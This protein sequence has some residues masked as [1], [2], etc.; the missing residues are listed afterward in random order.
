MSLIPSY[1]PVVSP[2]SRWFAMDSPKSG[3]SK[4]HITLAIFASVAL[5]LVTFK[6]MLQNQDAAL[7]NLDAC[8]EPEEPKQPTVWGG[9]QSVERIFVL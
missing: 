6:A 4:R 5:L 1:H 3:V 7:L 9:W 8:C 2:R